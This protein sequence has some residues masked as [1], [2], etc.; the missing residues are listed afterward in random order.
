MSSCTKTFLRIPTSPIQRCALFYCTSKD[1]AHDHV[2][3]V[4][5]P[6]KIREDRLHDKMKEPNV[7]RLISVVSTHQR[8]KYFECVKATL[9][10]HKTYLKLRD[11]C[12]DLDIMNTRI[13]TEH[14]VTFEDD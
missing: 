4:Y 14:I 11:C 10:K 9:F 8:Q 1:G 7:L 2:N 5:S 6:S 3:V 13:I 12:V